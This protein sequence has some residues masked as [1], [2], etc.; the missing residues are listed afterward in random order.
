M[1]NLWESLKSLLHPHPLPPT[2]NPPKNPNTQNVTFMHSFSSS[3]NFFIL[4]LIKGTVSMNSYLNYDSKIE[5]RPCPHDTPHRRPWTWI[6]RGEIL[7]ANH[8]F[9]ASTHEFLPCFV[10]DY[11]PKMLNISNSDVSARLKKYHKHT[12]TQTDIHIPTQTHT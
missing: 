12:H 11:M 8:P 9:K 3:H 10:F 5:M 7:T 6:V 2:P 4:L 1:I